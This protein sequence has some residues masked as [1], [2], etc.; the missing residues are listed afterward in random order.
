M[1]LFALQSSTQ[2]AAH[3]PPEQQYFPAGQELV[4]PQLHE[5][6]NGLELLCVHAQLG[7][8]HVPP[9]HA[10]PAEQMELPHMHC[11]GCGALPAWQEGKQLDLQVLSE[12]QYWPG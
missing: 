7:V 1:S 11:W 8:P 10:V 9:Q 6:A 12:Q 3:V 5:K 2:D 4:V